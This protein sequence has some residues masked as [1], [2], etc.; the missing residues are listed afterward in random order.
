MGHYISVVNEYNFQISYLIRSCPKGCCIDLVLKCFVVFSY[1][2]LLGLVVD[3]FDIFAGV[4]L[5]IQFSPRAESSM[6]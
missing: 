5:Y 6:C 2:N 3:K 4:F 1:L